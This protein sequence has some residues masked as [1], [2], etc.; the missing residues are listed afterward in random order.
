MDTELLL[1]CL[2]PTNTDCLKARSKARAA[3][4]PVTSAGEGAAPQTDASEHEAPR[5][6][7]QMSGLC[8]PPFGEDDVVG[9]PSLV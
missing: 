6:S 2:Q 7:L 4:E 5:G 9:I 1:Q 3:G 8:S